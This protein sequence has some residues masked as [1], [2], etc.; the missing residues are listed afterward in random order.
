[1]EN[2]LLL[3][4][5]RVVLQVRLWSGKWEVLESSYYCWLPAPHQM[6]G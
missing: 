1:M 5:E 4:L 2:E 3:S 6:Y